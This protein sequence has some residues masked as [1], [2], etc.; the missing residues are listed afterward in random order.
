M[1]LRGHVSPTPMP[2]HPRPSSAHAVEKVPRLAPLPPL[3]QGPPSPQ[4]SPCLGRHS[5]LLSIYNSPFRP[6]LAQLSALYQSGRK[7]RQRQWIPE[8]ERRR[9][10][11][12]VCAVFKEILVV[13]ISGITRRPEGGIWGQGLWEGAH[14]QDCLPSGSLPTLA[15]SCSRLRVSGQCPA[16]CLLASG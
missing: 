15:L 16:P 11:W 12:G 2:A 1:L 9:C 4:I 5:P 8:F 14:T 10:G 6:H 13:G 7:R 3:M